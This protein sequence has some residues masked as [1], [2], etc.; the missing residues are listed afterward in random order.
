MISKV[1]VLYYSP[2]FMGFYSQE[3]IWNPDTEMMRV[4]EGKYSM[5][6]LA[7]IYPQ[8]RLFVV[9]GYAMWRIFVRSLIL[10]YLIKQGISLRKE[11]LLVN[12]MLWDLYIIVQLWKEKKN[13][14]IKMV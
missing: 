12:V 13:I 1:S 3:R 10:W 7:R 14:D 9:K 5:K 11:S 4:R 2:V 6:I 8:H